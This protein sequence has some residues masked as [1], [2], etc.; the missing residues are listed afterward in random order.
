MAER[1]TV[2]PDAITAGTSVEMTLTYADY[3]ADG[4]WTLALL[5]N[6][7]TA[8]QLSVAGLTNGKS[9]NVTLSAANT[10]TL[11]TAAPPDGLGLHWTARLTNGTDIKDADEGDLLVYPDPTTAG[12]YHSQAEKDLTAIRAVLN[13][14]I[15]SDIEAYQIAGRAVTKIPIRDLIAL[16]D[17]LERRVD[18]EKRPGI[19]GPTVLPRFVSTS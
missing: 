1:L 3:P 6:G 5:F 16:R 11:G 2:V 7:P 15:T 10:V 8:N 17:S 18:A 12:A 9:F 19:M 4:G 14:R 13:G